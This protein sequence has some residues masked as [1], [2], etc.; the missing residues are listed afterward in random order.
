MGYKFQFVTL[1]GEC[2]IPSL[3]CWANAQSRAACGFACLLASPRRRGRCLRR[4]SPL[5]AAR[6]HS[7]RLHP[8]PVQATT[9]STSPC[10]SWRLA[11]A[12]AVRRAAHAALR[13]DVLRSCC[14]IPRLC[15]AAPA[16]HFVHICCV[17]PPLYRATC[18]APCPAVRH[19]IAAVNPAPLTG[20]L[21]PLA[22]LTSPHVLQAWLPTQSC[23]RRSSRARR[24]A[25][26]ERATRGRLQPGGHFCAC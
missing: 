7:D 4:P 21:C 19:A 13:C 17:H 11:T 6:T 2:C 1:A 8:F 9:P 18:A 20:C 14:A 12:T 23:S 5:L 16:N 22:H 3:Q 25:T 15:R 26:P 10:S 24:T